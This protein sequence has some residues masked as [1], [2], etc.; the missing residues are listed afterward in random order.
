LI[1]A[2][3][4]AEAHG[5]HAWSF[6]TERALQDLDATGVGGTPE[7]PATPRRDS[8]VVREVAAGLEAYAAAGD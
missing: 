1:E 5:L 4:I 6:R 2:R 7:P 8:P 3:A